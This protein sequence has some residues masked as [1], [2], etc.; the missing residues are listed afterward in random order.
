MKPKRKKMAPKGEKWVR[1]QV[2]LDPET[3]A[4]AERDAGERGLFVSAML[5]TI[6]RAHY[7]AKPG[8]A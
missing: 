4:T 7:A 6:I 3:L 2:M 1:V 8:A 5:R